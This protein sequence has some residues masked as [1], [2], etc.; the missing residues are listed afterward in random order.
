MHST[1]SGRIPT[2]DVARPQ[3][4]A[5]SARYIIWE[6]TGIAG[7]VNAAFHLPNS[8]CNNGVLRFK[9]IFNYGLF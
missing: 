9:V 1:E 6:L 5:L 4:P 2:W 3:A 7:N 8:I